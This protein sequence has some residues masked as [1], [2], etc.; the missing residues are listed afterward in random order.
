MNIKV[1]FLIN[2]ESIVIV[3]Q[4]GKH[5][6]GQENYAKNYKKKKETKTTLG[7]T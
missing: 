5:L 1:C 6:I 3:Y 2:H 7:Y 4:F